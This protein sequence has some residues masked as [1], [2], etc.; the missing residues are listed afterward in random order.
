MIR[1]HKSILLLAMTSGMATCLS[2]QETAT[3]PM[4]VLTVESAQVVYVS[5]DDVVLKL[6]DGSL[7]LY[8]PNAGAPLMIDGK[9]AKPS[10]LSPGTNISHVKLH[11]QVTSDVTSVEEL[12][13]RISAKKGRVLTLRLADG[14]PKMYRVPN[15]ATFKVNEKDTEY[16]NIRDGMT[17]T[18]TVVTTTGLT[19]HST[20]TAK[21]PN[22]PSQQGTLVIQNP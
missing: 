8:E 21:V 17:I 19:S 16:S 22:T 5:G 15:H 13:G 14:T 9:E 2:A 3:T 20:N 10:D 12:S 7:F 6:P 4:S 18:V 11:T 1:F